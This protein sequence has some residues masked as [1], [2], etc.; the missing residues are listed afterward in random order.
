[1]EKLILS[2][3]ARFQPEKFKKKSLLYIVIHPPFILSET[4]PEKALKVCKHT[5]FNKIG[6]KA[7]TC[8]YCFH[9]V[10][11]L[12]KSVQRGGECLKII[13]FERTYFMDGPI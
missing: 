10:I 8:I 4:S 12:L 1:M 9:D 3:I 7:K 11:M 13:K 5:F 2:E 6:V